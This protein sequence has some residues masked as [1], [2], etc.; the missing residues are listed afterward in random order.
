MSRIL[1][2]FV[3]PVLNGENDIGRCLSSIRKLDFPGDAFEIIV[4]DNGS[5]DETPR[6]VQEF[7]VALHR[8]P[9]LHVGGVRNRGVSLSRG[10]YIAFVDADVELMPQWLRTGLPMFDDRRL[11][12][13]G[14]FPRVPCAAT[15]VQRTWD[16]HQ[17]RRWSAAEKTKVAW[18]PS[19]N[20]IVRRDA[21]LSI[22]GFNESLETAEDVD[23]CYR[24]A[25]YGTILSVPAMEAVH[26]GE[27][28]DLRTF[29][30]KEVWRG[31]GNLAGVVNHGFRWDELPSIAYPLYVLGMLHV[32][33]ITLFMMVQGWQLKLIP[34]NLLLLGL[35]AFVFAAVTSYKAK[36][37]GAVA[38]L[39]LLY[40][41]YGVARAYSLAGSL[42]Q[43]FGVKR[44]IW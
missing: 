4:V 18:L 19:M 27:A 3:I 2:S 29:G 1:V 11:V 42:R 43:S 23:L 40:F 25:R 12:A 36:Q 38:K 21:F 32:L 33:V 9:S 17:R 7:D 24:L 31:I 6:V 20:L 39:F 35:P 13:I 14:C 26:W 41:V 28:A 16:V 5:T 10:E 15:W 22:G 37:F 34:I 8:F 44:G 30:R